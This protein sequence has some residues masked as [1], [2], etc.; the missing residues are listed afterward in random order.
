M[1][2]TFY[3]AAVDRLPLH[4][5]DTSNVTDMSGMFED[6]MGSSLYLNI[7]DWD[8]TSVT[9]MSRMFART[10]HLTSL[11]ISGW[12]TR[13]VEN[14]RGM[15]YR[16]TSLRELHLG[17]YFTFI[18]AEASNCVALPS[19]PQNDYFT[20]HWQNV[21]M[22]T[23]VNPRGTY[24]FTSN[25]LVQYFDGN[26]M[27]DIWVWQPSHMKPEPNRSISGAF[28]IPNPVRE[29]IITLRNSTTGQ[30]ILITGIPAPPN[31]YTT[32]EFAFEN[33]YPGTY[34]ISIFKQ[35]HTSFTINNIVVTLTDDVDLTQDPRFPQQLPLLPGN[36]TGNGQVNILDLNAMLQNWMGSCENAN[37]TGSGQVNASDL[38]L[39][40]RN[41]MAESV[42]VD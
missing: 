36:I 30:R 22:G 13:N 39:L 31:A 42:V 32:A 20:G 33:L 15:F 11:D 16:T 37:L 19:V 34:S 14:M 6:V 17:Q 8:V 21:G 4:N 23:T 26:T 5:W 38:N 24:V 12:D 2:N 9:D 27:A 10:P 41:W 25:Q 28:T 29:I 35:G 1:S 3:R 7:A 18:T 40:L